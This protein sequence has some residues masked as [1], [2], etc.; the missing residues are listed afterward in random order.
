MSWRSV[1]GRTG[2]APE[3][4]A[5]IYPAPFHAYGGYAGMQYWISPPSF[6]A[7]IVQQPYIPPPPPPPQAEPYDPALSASNPDVPGRALN[8]GL[9]PDA[10]YIFPEHHAQVNVI[11]PSLDNRFVLDAENDNFT[12]TPF[13]VPTAIQ[14][15][16]FMRQ[17]GAGKAFTEALEQGNGVWRAG[18]VIKKE[19]V[20]KDSLA[21]LGW[22]GAGF[23]TR[24]PIWIVLE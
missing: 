2:F 19:D 7:I 18:P 4:Q 12:F 1:I 14:I 24:P 20:K 5:A 13:Q 6:G 16:E 17:I 3:Q 23:S 11:R 9:L 22:N 15:T 10:T 21:S 8:G